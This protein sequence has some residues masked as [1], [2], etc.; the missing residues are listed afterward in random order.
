[1]STVLKSNYTSTVTRSANL[2][3]INELLDKKKRKKFKI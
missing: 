3:F 1:M 2:A